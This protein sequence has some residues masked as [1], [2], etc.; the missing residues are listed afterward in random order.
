MD[1]SRNE[2]SLL[3]WRCHDISAD[4]QNILG[5]T[6]CQCISVG[7]DE[8]SAKTL[9]SGENNKDEADAD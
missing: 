4:L 1:K 3:T 8:V 6:C 7:T 9:D 5:N 2:H